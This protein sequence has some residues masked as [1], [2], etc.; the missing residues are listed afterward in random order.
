MLHL[1]AWLALKCHSANMDILLTN[2]HTFVPQDSV[3]TYRID[4]IIESTGLLNR[5]DY[6]I[7]WIIESTGLLNHEILHLFPSG[8]HLLCRLVSK[9][10]LSKTG[11]MWI[12]C[13]EIHVHGCRHF[14]DCILLLLAYFRKKFEI[15]LSHMDFIIFNLAQCI[16]SMINLT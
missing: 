13:I 6:R 3:L 4:W 9:T 2:P 8:I 1:A 11:L 10:G 5:L 12:D 15:N 7:D 16:Y 14:H